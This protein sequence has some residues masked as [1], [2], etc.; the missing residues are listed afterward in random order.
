MGVM[1]TAPEASCPHLS[2]DRYKV[3]FCHTPVGNETGSYDCRLSGP[4][5]HTCQPQG[6]KFLE[7]PSKNKMSTKGQR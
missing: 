2:R 5:K 4:T 3:L 6:E 7:R 1:M